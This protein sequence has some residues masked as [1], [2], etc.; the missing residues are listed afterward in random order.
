M[1]VAIGGYER[2]WST[3]ADGFHDGL[4]VVQSVL[5]A[6]DGAWSAWRLHDRAVRR[7][8][9]VYGLKS[10]VVDQPRHDLFCLGV[11]S[12][13]PLHYPLGAATPGGVCLEGGGERVEHL[14]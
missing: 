5:L 12:A 7:A 13:E 2:N 4:G 10:G 14:V 6:I 8:A 3:C 11:V 9:Q 1:S